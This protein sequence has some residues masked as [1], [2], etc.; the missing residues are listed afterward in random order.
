[1]LLDRIRPDVHVKS[2][3]YREEELARANASCW[4]TAAESRSRRT[5]AGTSTTETIARILD[6]YSPHG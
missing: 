4:H 2:D 6:A 1:M 5:S 3:Q